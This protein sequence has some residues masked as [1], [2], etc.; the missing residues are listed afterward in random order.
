MYK[1][2]LSYCL[3][4]ICCIT[5]I[6]QQKIIV[7]ASGNGMYSTIQAAINNLPD[8]ANQ[9]RIIII[10]KGVYKEKL[11]ITKHNIALVGEDKNNTIIQQSIARDNWRCSNATDWGVATINISSNDI[12]FFNLT[13]ENN[14]G[15]DYKN[16]VEIPCPLDT[17]QPTKKVKNNGHQMALRTID[18]ATRIMAVN[19]SFISAGGDTVS[20]WNVNNGMFYFKDCF[21]Q[22]GVDLYCPRGWAWAEN[23]TFKAVNG[24]AIVWHDGSIHEQSKSI[25]SNCNFSGYNGFLIGRYHRDAQ[26]YLLQCTFNSNAKDSAIY[27]VPTNNIIQWGHRIY[28]YNCNK[29]GNFNTSWYANNM[30]YKQVQNITIPSVF[31]NAWQPHS[32]AQYIIYNTYAT[33][34]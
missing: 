4:T 11:L 24:T 25:I 23:C 26:M 33:I 13:V 16:D 5:A 10:K 31:N 7:D 30:A 18:N 9:Q 6:C 1:K 12:A 22:G 3:L 8:T 29:A 19:C 15:S 14:Y 28:Y 20:P 17:V 2:L 34:K 32:I 21:I 27:R